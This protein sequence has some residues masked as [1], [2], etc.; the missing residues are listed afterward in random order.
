MS[1]SLLWVVQKNVSILLNISLDPKEEW[2]NGIYQNSNYMQFYISNSGI[3]ERFA[4]HYN[5]YKDP[6]KFRKTR[7]KNIEDLL[8]KLNIFFE[9]VKN[10]LKLQKN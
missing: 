8:N 4:A 10:D 2:N 9:K 7:V 6:F 3:I 1:N 5:L